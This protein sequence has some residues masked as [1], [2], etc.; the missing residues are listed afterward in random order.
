MISMSDSAEIAPPIKTIIP[1]VVHSPIWY[2]EISY[3]VGGDVPASEVL[4][5]RLCT[6]ILLSGSGLWRMKT[7]WSTCLIKFTMDEDGD[8]DESDEEIVLNS[9]S[10]IPD[11]LRAE[12]TAS[13]EGPEDECAMEMSSSPAG[14]TSKI[15]IEKIIKLIQSI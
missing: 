2:A 8:G 15:Q 7:G 5:N 4:V 12:A 13:K 3:S 11:F 9:T 10:M 14:K 6:S 1:I